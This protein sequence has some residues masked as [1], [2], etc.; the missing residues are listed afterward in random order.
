[1]PK[2][3]IEAHELHGTDVNFVSLVKR[4]ANRLPFR[5]VKED[6]ADMLNLADLQRVFRKADQAPLD[7]VGRVVAAVVRKGAD[8]EAAKLRLGQAGLTVDDMQE[9]GELI[10]FRQP[11]VESAN[12]ALVKLDDDIG[13]VVSGLAKAFEGFNVED[14][15]FG[16]VFA[17]EAFFPSMRLAKDMLG[18]TV[19]D[20]MQKAETPG[21]A[22]S[23]IAKAVDD[24]KTYVSALAAAI[25]QHAFKADLDPLEKSVTVNLNLNTPSSNIEGSPT[26]GNATDTRLTTQGT[27]NAIESSPTAG[28]ETPRNPA[29]KPDIGTPGA[30]NDIEGSPIAKADGAKTDPPAPDPAAVDPAPN[31]VVDGP[32]GD[33]AAA[34]AKSMEE[35]V[36]AGLAGLQTELASIGKRLDQ[37]EQR[38]QKTE[39]AVNGTVAAEAGSDRTG[40][41]KAA[42]RRVPPLLDTAFMKLDQQEAA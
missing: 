35:V 20:I 4:G 27:N 22:A 42:A 19:G 8:L 16:K 38:A 13:L 24:F 41:Q 1:M 10:V 5:I 40:V 6:Q 34:L 14:T 36:K 2:L 30:A 21:E 15:D 31:P 26:H 39:I 23:L 25:P 37:V 7:Q 28:N 11:N 32:A 17:T 12:D 18:C 29:T 3:Q 33:Q 9:D